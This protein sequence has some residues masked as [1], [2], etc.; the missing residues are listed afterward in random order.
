M[1]CVHV[2]DPESIERKAGVS[3]TDDVIQ[4]DDANVRWEYVIGLQPREGMAKCG[5]GRATAAFGLGGSWKALDR[6]D[7]IPRRVGDENHVVGDVRERPR[8][9]EGSL[10]KCRKS[11]RVVV[12]DGAQLSRRV[13][14]TGRNY[15]SFGVD[16]GKFLHQ[17][18]P[19][20]V[21]LVVCPAEGR[22]EERHG[23]S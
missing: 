16:L 4:R 18:R 5:A 10:T 3:R 15:T 7:R 8:R 14:R 9:R 13:I 6:C 20:R 12:P 19:P 1:M 22:I 17:G 11:L 21:T 23:D 2:G